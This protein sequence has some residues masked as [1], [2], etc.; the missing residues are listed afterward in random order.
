M[1]PRKKLRALGREKQAFRIEFEEGGRISDLNSLSTGEKQIV[2]RGGF[3]LRELDRARSGIILID[4]PELS[5]HPEWQ[6]RIVGF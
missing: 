1:F 2:F 5:L 6:S 4:E 3:L